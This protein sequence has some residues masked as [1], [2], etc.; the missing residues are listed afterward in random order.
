M[1]RHV[2]VIV[3]NCQNKSTYKRL[4]SAVLF[5]KWPRAPFTSHSVYKHVGQGEEG[6]IKCM[7]GRR[8]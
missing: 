6:Y 7:N 8:G 5:L 4:S 2:C 3:F 1:C